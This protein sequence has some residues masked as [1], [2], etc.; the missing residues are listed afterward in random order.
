MNLRSFKI[1]VVI[2]FLLLGL[3]AG[4]LHADNI[5]YLTSLEW[6]PYV[7]QLLPGKGTSAV[8]VRKAFAAMG[9]DL[10]IL[11]LPWKRTMHKVDTDS[12]VI[13]YFPEY[14]SRDRAEKYIFSNSYGCSPI[15][16]LERKKNPA[17]WETVDD[18]AG[19]RVGFVS[20]YVN[21]RE[22]DD[23]IAN[24]TIKADFT[25]TDKSNIMKLIKGRIDYA[26]VDPM[27]YRYMAETDPEVKK[28]NNLVQIK[29][30][31]FGV[32]ELFVAF[33]KDRQGRF[34]ARIFNEGL[35]KIGIGN[36]CEN[37]DKT[38]SSQ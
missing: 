29:P 26:V 10:R 30:R 36:S 5:V 22:L 35:K 37:D 27:V 7:G 18:L 8:T 2:S 1:C 12:K 16:L 9:Y 4:N 28:Y 11:F 19:L 6:P 3:N 15:G 20:G 24:G 23:A 21:T 25:S 38:I 33:R 13:G 31:N 32:N 34:Y 14:Y 17:A